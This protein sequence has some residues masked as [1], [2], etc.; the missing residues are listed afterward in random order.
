MISSGPIQSIRFAT[1]AGKSI[2][3]DSYERA[4]EIAAELGM[5]AVKKKGTPVAA[6]SYRPLPA[7]TSDAQRKKLAAKLAREAMSDD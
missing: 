3:A 7:Y 2:T 1:V 4:V 6:W 5:G